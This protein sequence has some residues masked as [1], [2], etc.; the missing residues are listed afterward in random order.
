[1][2]ASNLVI[3]TTSDFFEDIEFNLN[4]RCHSKELGKMH[5]LKGDKKSFSRC[6]ISMCPL[7]Y[8]QVIALGSVFGFQKFLLADTGTTADTTYGVEQT[9]YDETLNQLYLDKSFGYWFRKAQQQEDTSLI[10]LSGRHE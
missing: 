10:Y 2:L 9:K 7:S 4:Y 6:V 3:G 5:H 1:M 8:P